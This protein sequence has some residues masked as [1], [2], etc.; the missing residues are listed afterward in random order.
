MNEDQTEK[1]RQQHNSTVDSGSQRDAF[2]CSFL[3]EGII[4]VYR[5]LDWQNVEGLARYLPVT[6]PGM[7]CAE[8]I[9]T[10]NL[11]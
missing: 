1:R 9:G 10:H 2:M 8:V 5:V 7:G 4:H 6:F 11:R 3:P